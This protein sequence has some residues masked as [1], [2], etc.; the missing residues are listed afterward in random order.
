MGNRLNIMTKCTGSK[1]SAEKIKVWNGAQYLKEVTMALRKMLNSKFLAQATY[2]NKH[3]YLAALFNKLI[4][5]QIPEWLM[6]GVTIRFPKNE[7]NQ[8]TK[9][10]HTCDL[11]AYNTISRHMQKYVDDE[12]PMQKEQKGCCRGSKG[13]KDQ[14]L[15]L[16]VILQES[17]NR[18]KLLCMAWTSFQ[19]ALDSVPHSWVVKSL[20]LIRIC[21]KTKRTV[22]YWRTSM[23]L[24]TEEKLVET[25]DTEV[26][27]GMF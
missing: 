22:S 21:N 19:K 24:H 20:E 4:R 5:G 6:A 7:K 10:L 1:T 11:S 16:K 13:C 27:C 15:M 17:K 12:K 3:K 25:E 9:G 2:R 18:K 26:Q 8:T 23:H 14:L